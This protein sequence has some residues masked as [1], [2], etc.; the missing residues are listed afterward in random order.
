MLPAEVKLKRGKFKPY[1]CQKKIDLGTIS[2]E[3]IRTQEM[4][5]S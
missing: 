4:H 2:G 3:F 5:S 1:Y